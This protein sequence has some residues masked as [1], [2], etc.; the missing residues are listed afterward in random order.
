[1]EEVAFVVIRGENAEIWGR[2][3]S[4]GEGESWGW[5]VGR[6]QGDTGA[7]ITA[8]GSRFP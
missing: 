8:Q 3:S 1:M 7:V 2:P 4:K 5:V 6:W